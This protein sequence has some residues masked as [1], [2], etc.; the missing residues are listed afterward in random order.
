MKNMGK[1][2]SLREKTINGLLAILLVV[3]LLTLSV[4][5]ATNESAVGNETD[6]NESIGEVADIGDNDTE[7]NGTETANETEIPGDE[8][9]T[10]EVED[11][12][13]DGIP[14]NED[15]CPNVAGLECNDGCSTETD[16]DDD[17]LQEDNPRCPEYDERLGDHDND[18]ISE[19]LDCDDEDAKNTKTKGDADSDGVGNCIDEC[20]HQAGT[21]NGCPIEEKPD[22]K[23]EANPMPA[24]E[25]PKQMPKVKPMAQI[26]DY[27]LNDGV[28]KYLVIRN[29]GLWDF[30]TQKL[31]I[32]L[33]GE[34]VEFSADSDTT[35]SGA[36]IYLHINHGISPEKH[37][38]A[39]THEGE[40][41]DSISV[42]GKRQ[43][44]EEKIPPVFSMKG[45]SASG[46][47][48]GQLVAQITNIMYNPDI[49]GQ[50][51]ITVPDDVEVYGAVG[52]L[53][54]KASY[55]TQ[56]IV[57]TGDARYIEIPLTSSIP[58]DYRVSAVLYWHFK[59]DSTIHQIGFDKTIRIETND[60]DN[61]GVPDF[62]EVK[63]GTNANNAD[64]DGDGIPDGEDAYP[65]TAKTKSLAGI[66]GGGALA[67]VAENDLLVIALALIIVIGIWALLT[68]T[69]VNLRG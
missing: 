45:M 36:A 11:S 44:S 38:I 68:K 23:S 9:E 31:E 50:I 6:V 30:A 49:V 1:V 67:W 39:I 20:P 41:L 14:D 62:M 61:D 42:Y 3:G 52:G 8:N 16:K 24:P 5:A 63:Q 46:N 37:T 4:T 58:G 10:I 65:L 27:E 32:S 7:G 64:T 21:K 33:D 48:P 40:I 47:N 57:P 60:K 17:G 56:Y 2:V 54:G 25:I 59:G 22:E 34:K 19:D 55:V 28:L 26:E 15:E 29:T 51:I 53:S 35:S 66:S 18:G 43:L 12:D 13:N 69:V